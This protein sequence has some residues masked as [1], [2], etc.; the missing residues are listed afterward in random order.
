MK[1]F[2]ASPQKKKPHY[3][4]SHLLDFFSK[5]CQNIE[6]SFLIKNCVD[7]K[8]VAHFFYSSYATFV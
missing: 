2:L 5:I 4:N 7:E 6:N 1:Y 3:N 8:N